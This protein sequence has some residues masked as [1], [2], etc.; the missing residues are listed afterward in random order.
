MCACMFVG[1]HMWHCVH[2]E[3]RGQ[4]AALSSF[5]GPRDQIQMASPDNKCLYLLSYLS[6]RLFL[7]LLFGYDYIFEVRSLCAVQTLQG[8][9]LK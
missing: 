5:L 6:Q 9:G 7:F 3:V 2:V 1:E 8:L 4:L